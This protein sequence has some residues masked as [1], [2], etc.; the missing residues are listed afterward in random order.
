LTSHSTGI[1]RQN[2]IECICQPD[3][4]RFS[5]YTEAAVFRLVYWASVST[6]GRCHSHHH[7]WLAHKECAVP[8]GANNLQSSQ[9]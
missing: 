4:G 6:Y 2:Q 3:I 1:I 8:I 7:F 9:L 5:C